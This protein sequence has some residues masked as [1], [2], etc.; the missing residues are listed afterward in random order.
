MLLTCGATTL[1][2]MTFSINT[3][4]IKNL[5]LT[6][7]RNDPQHSNTLT[8][9]WVSRFMYCFAE[10]HYAECRYAECPGVAGNCSAIANLRKRLKIFKWNLEFFLKTKYKLY[11]CAIWAGRPQ[12]KI[13][14]GCDFG[15]LNR[16]CKQILS[17]TGPVKTAPLR[18]MADSIDACKCYFR[19]RS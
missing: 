11:C 13:A 19:E 15:R 3:L 18:E 1:S 17:N 12:S 5:V 9:C 8:F 7:C 10:C 6:F 16:T 14:P 2:I 4:S